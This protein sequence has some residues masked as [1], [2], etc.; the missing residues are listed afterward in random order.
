MADE[1]AFELARAHYPTSL[2]MLQSHGF[3]P[4][5]LIDLG[6]A[7]AAF[8]LVRRQ[9]GLFPEARHFFVD[10]MEENEPLYRK[11]GEK[12]GT[13]Y[14]IAAVASSEGETTMRIDPNFYDTYVEDLRSQADYGERRAVRRTTLDSL[15]A[16][17]S[18][19]PPFAIKLDLQGG[20][21]DALRGG[22]GTLKQAILVNSEVGVCNER[23]N[24]VDLMAL[25]RE[26][27][28]VLFD[29]TDLSYAR[30]NHTLYQVYATFVPV[31]MDF[32]RG[33]AWAT[34]EQF[35]ELRAQLRERRANNIEAIEELLRNA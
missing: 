28:W 3:R 6:A 16:R 12:F 22:P 15:V 1:E 7:E 25:M 30:S 24:L 20:E 21:V 13:G 23:D 35:A 14:E 19:K 4:A 26:A 9:L 29:I 34:E 27:G 32:R 5:T 33:Q 11:L 8:L 18:L 17:H 2:H 10:A 31:A